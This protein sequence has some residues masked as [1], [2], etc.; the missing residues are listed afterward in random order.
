MFFP[1]DSHEPWYF[2]CNVCDICRM[3]NTLENER[4]YYH[5]RIIGI[6]I[7]T[8]WYDDKLE[9]FHTEEFAFNLMRSGRLKLTRQ[10]ELFAP[11]G[12]PSLRLFYFKLAIMW[13]TRGN[14]RSFFYYLWAWLRYFWHPSNYT[15][16]VLS[17]VSNVKEHVRSLILRVW[18]KGF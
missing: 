13:Y 7:S 16:T 4:R 6:Y 2:F 11:I 9:L 17:N 3:N 12:Y 1:N 14:E 5:S 18:P 10:I 15:V 8:Q